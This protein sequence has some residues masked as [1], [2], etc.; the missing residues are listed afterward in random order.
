MDSVVLLPTHAHLCLAGD[1]YPVVPC[2]SWSPTHILVC[3]VLTPQYEPMTYAASA[4]VA[5][6]ASLPPLVHCADD[7]VHENEL[8]P[9]AR[10]QERDPGGWAYPPAQ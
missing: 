8:T 1:A 7:P 4:A 3:V 10:K 2:K 5:N 6:V 9:S